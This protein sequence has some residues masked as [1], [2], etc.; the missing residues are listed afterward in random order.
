MVLNPRSLLLALA[1][2]DQRVSDKMRF[3]LESTTP[4]PG[5]VGSAGE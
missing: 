2:I 4:V 1:A 5:V 3:Y